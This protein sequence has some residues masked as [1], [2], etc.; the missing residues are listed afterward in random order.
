MAT[1]AI[2][3]GTAAVAQT[4]SKTAWPVVT[5]EDKQAVAGVLERRVLW[6]MTTVEGLYA[7]EQDALEQE[8]AA[9]LGVKRT[10]AVNGGTS[11]LHM[12]AVAA[13]VEAGD[14]VITSAYSF[15]ATPAAILHAGAIPVFVDIDRRTW[16]LDPAKIEAKITSR[17]KA[18]L[19]V[20]IHGLCADWDAILAVAEK[21]GLQVIE[22]AC[23]APGATYK[24]RSAGSFG[25]AA[26]F[27]TNGTKNFAV[28][29]GGFLA[30]NDDEAFFRA[31]WIKQ[32]GETL[33]ASNRTME[34]QH[35]LAWNYR[36]QE[37]PCALARTQLRR[38]AAVNAQG[39][40]NAAIMDGYLQDIPGLRAPHIPA[41]CVSVYHKYRITLVPEELNTPLRGQALRDAFM[42]ALTAEGVDVD[43]WGTAPLPAHPMLTAHHGFGKGFP[44]SL[45]GDPEQY[46]YRAEDYPV[47]LDMFA[48]SFCLTNDEYPIYAQPEAVMHAFGE[49]LRKVA[50]HAGELHEAAAWQT[51]T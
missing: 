18:I 15:L 47:A 50:Q 46:V 20:D 10:I 31:N 37:M 39:R 44:W 28:G 42:A 34:F 38:L 30:T 43:L 24:G 36:V 14:E 17:T 26:G 49:A 13:G 41:D 33:P 22:D 32:V 19:A 4:L 11:A 25:K 21:H 35:L 8:F 16:N 3:G 48:N 40:R 12:A 2:S 51:A 45:N 27:S 1:L 7:P 5:A 23:Q 9:F 29:E 6:A